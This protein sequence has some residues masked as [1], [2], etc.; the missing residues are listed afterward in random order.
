MHCIF[1]AGTYCVPSIETTELRYN[2]LEKK[3][4]W[5]HMKSAIVEF[6]QRVV[7]QLVPSS[8]VPKGN[9]E[10]AQLVNIQPEF[11]KTKQREDY[12]SSG[13]SLGYS[14]SQS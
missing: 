7:H 8:P 12:I 5:L 3:I 10:C 11:A 6:G 14:T 1:S 4:S 13:R 9:H 2:I